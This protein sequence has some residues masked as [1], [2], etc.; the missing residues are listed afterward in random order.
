[1]VQRLN[2]SAN[3]KQKTIE[4]YVID[5]LTELAFATELTESPKKLE[6]TSSPELSIAA[7]SPLCGKKVFIVSKELKGI[8]SRSGILAQ[9]FVDA[10]LAFEGM[11]AQ[12]SQAGGVLF[13]DNFAHIE[14]V[15]TRDSGFIVSFYGDFLKFK[16]INPYIARG[17]G[18][19]YSRMTVR[20]DAELEAAIQ[21]IPIAQKLKH[22]M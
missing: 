13:S 5:L 21:S 1:V 18:P 6:S 8:S 10:M 22:G 19:S 17:R 2:Q 20:T 11:T 12:I 4:D 16:V 7:S 3:N 9:K 15:Y 14:R